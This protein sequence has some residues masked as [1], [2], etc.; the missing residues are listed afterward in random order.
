[1]ATFWVT[2]VIPLPMTAMLP[3]VLFPMFGIMK[4]SDVSPSVNFKI[5]KVYEV[6]R[7]FRPKS[8]LFNYQTGDVFADCFTVC[9]F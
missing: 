3:A 5:K 2:E 9:F 1:M 7:S 6:F 8:L 4:A